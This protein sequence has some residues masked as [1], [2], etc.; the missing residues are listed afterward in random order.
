MNDLLVIRTKM[1]SKIANNNFLS[2]Y[3][4][5]DLLAASTIMRSKVFKYIKLN[6]LLIFSPNY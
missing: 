5:K 1:K 6:L 4:M 2:F 3:L